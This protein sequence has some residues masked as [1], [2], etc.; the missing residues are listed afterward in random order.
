MNTSCLVGTPPLTGK[1]INTVWYL[2][3]VADCRSIPI[4]RLHNCRSD[5]RSFHNFHPFLSP[6]SKRSLSALL[7]YIATALSR[8]LVSFKDILR[9][10]R[11]SLF[12]RVAWIS[13]RHSVSSALLYSSAPLLLF[14]LPRGIR[15]FI[16]TNLFSPS[17]N[18]FITGILFLPC[19]CALLLHYLH[20][21]VPA[22]LD[23][24]S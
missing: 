14:Y 10:A 23:C 4:S 13:S 1:L 17:C 12:R 24:F 11:V 20:H 16:P 8:G 19:F 6:T 2:Q 22:S 21:P 9:A 7:F 5:P 18:P 15:L 3:S